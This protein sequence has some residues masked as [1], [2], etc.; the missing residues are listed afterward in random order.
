[1]LQD[2]SSPLRDL[3]LRG[4]KRIGDL[5]VDRGIFGD[6]ATDPGAFDGAA[7][8]AYNASPRRLHGGLKALRLVLA[9]DS[10]VRAWPRAG[11]HPPCRAQSLEGGVQWSDA[12][13]PGPPAEGTE[14]VVTQQGVSIRVSGTVAGSCG[15]FDL[16]RLALSQARVCRRGGCGSCGASW[17][18]PSPG[19]C[20]M[21]PRRRTAWR[22]PRTSRLRWAR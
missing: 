20:A 7:D 13:C 5:V 14:P 18:A 1:M 4:V 21:A 22:W 8:R 2:L 10:A 17:A 6:V 15:E 3:R 19:R 9:L 11:R 16:Y 12:R